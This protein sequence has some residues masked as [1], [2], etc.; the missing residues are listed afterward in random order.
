MG[1]RVDAVKPENPKSLPV[2]RGGKTT[3]Q[4]VR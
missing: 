4:R 1:R 3:N 2:G